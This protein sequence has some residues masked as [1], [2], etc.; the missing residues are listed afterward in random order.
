MSHA[1]SKKLIKQPRT[2]SLPHTPQE[3]TGIDLKAAYTALVTAYERNSHRQM[4]QVRP[5]TDKFQER[6]NE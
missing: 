4:N 1:L 6:K 5:F 2:Q 3:T